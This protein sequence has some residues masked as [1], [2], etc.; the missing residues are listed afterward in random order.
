MTTNK[1]KQL[2]QVQNILDTLQEP[3]EHL[4]T[5]IKNKV[6]NQ[7]IYTFSSIVEGSQAVITMVH[8]A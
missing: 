6:L 4:A 3:T 1:E 5:L 7:S 8:C 2:F